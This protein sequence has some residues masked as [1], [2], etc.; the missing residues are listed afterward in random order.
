M[1]VQAGGKIGEAHE[2]VGRAPPAKEKWSPNLS[3][4]WNHLGGLKND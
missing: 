1:G 4:P 3:V 2:Q